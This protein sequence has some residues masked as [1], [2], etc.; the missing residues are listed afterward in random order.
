MK[1]KKETTVKTFENFVNTESKVNEE[2]ERD[3]NVNRARTTL[4]KAIVEYYKKDIA[5]NPDDY[6]DPY[7]DVEDDVE[8]FLESMGDAI[9]GELD[10]SG[11]LDY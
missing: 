7:D 8:Y 4:I 3:S 11:V 9:L 10:R 2:L 5:E 1:K 6:L